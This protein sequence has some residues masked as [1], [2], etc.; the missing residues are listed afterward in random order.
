MTEPTK[1]ETRNSDKKPLEE[2]QAAETEA[3]IKARK[4][5]I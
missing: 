4:R 3:Q 2:V 5:T 1:S